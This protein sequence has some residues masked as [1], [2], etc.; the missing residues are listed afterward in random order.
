VSKEMDDVRS[1]LAMTTEQISDQE[2]AEWQAKQ[3]PRYVVRA[4]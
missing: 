3:P 2:R 4:A 1:A